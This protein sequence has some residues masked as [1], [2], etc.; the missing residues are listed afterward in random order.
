MT[1][2]RSRHAPASAGR[3]NLAVSRPRRHASASLFLACAWLLGSCA[4]YRPKPLVPAD[5][6]ESLRSATLLELRIEHTRPGEGGSPADSFNP[7][8]GINEGELVAVALTLNPTLRTIR[9]ELGESQA[10]LIQA[11]LWPNPE[12]GAAVRPELGGSATGVELDFLFALLRPG[13][14]KA[15]RSIAKAVIEESRSRIIGEELRVAAEARAARLLVIGAEATLRLFEQE[16]EIR[17]EVAS[18][19][20]QRR[21]LGEATVLDLHLAELELIESERAVR[22]ARTELDFTRR[23]LN[24]VLGLPPLYELQLFAAG[25]ALTFTVFEDLPDSELDSRILSG[26]PELASKQAAYQKAEEEL[27]LAV[28]RQYPSLK[29]GP[30]YEKDVEGSEAL[31]LG[32]SLELPL[33]DRSQGAIAEK[34][35]ARERVR[36]EYVALLHAVRA[37]AFDAR[38]RVR[39]AKLEVETQETQALPLVERSESAFEEAFRTRD[40]N[41]FEWLTA[42]G[43]A[44][45]A[46]REFLGAL[47]RYSESVVD[48]E[49]ATGAAL[50]RPAEDQQDK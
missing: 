3:R 16:A 14:R 47:L 9:A 39:R 30:S 38:E 36:A 21:E 46:R 23:E 17:R 15:R 31:G 13:E 8:D 12:L 19:V 49:T 29:L 34:H 18:L 37:E 4:S 50:S 45:R 44:L 28:L 48:L 2:F 40:V 41:V 27:R 35:A 33:F 26:R 1:T 20:R 43:Q 42:R 5:E 25:N 32:A 7:N 6:L 10:L 11:G 24:R 22:A